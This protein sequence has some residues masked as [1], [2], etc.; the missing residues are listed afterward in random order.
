MMARALHR[1]HGLALSLSWVWLALIVYAS[2]FPIVG[3]R[4]PPGASL[5]DLMRL[6]WTRWIGGFDALSNLLGYLPLGGLLTLV[7]LQRQRSFWRAALWAAVLCTLLSYSMEV[8]QHFVPKRVPT[9]LDLAMNGAGA[10]LGALLA[11]GLEASGLR[12]R[13]HLTQERWL[14]HGG[15]LAAV[16]LMLWPVALLFPSP[17]PFGLGQIGSHLRDMA[18]A[19]LEGVAWAG[20]LP[21]W[22]ESAE[23]FEP[24]SLVTEWTV[25]VLGLLAPCL[26]A[27]AASMPSW[28][29]IW[30]AMGVPV[31]ACAAT[32]LST[33]L[34]FGPQHALA[35]LTP[36]VISALCVA[37]LLSLGLFWIGPRLA[38]SL[39]L[40]ALTAL[41]ALVHTAPVD[42]YFAQSLQAW[43]QGAFIRF[44]GLAKWVGWLWPYAAITWLLSRH[45]VS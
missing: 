27:Y 20:R 44:H 40:V 42:P 45:R 11:L 35:W 13:W 18:L 16:L 5:W 26:V 9:A 25:A 1:P 24:A 7:R 2:L 32:S 37:T 36:V 41:I 15:R 39:A 10:A 22:L 4:A 31:L 19:A 8:L 17:L 14:E 21:Q 12:R 34:N 43:E 33:A 23:V 3:W 28:R 30:L 29:R 6:P 38:G